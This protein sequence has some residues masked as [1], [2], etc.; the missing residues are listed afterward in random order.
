MAAGVG[1]RISRNIHGPKC[2]L[3]VGGEPL[4]HKTV[5][6]LIRN[7][8]KV[9]VVLGYENTF[10]K[11]ALK[12]L[13]VEYYYNPFYRVTNSIA[14]LWFARDF[15]DED[16]ILANADVF[17]EQDILTELLKEKHPITMLADKSR[18]NKGDYFFNVELDYLVD[19]G[20]ELTREQRTSEYVGIAKITSENNQLSLFKK[21]LEEMIDLGQYDLWWENVL[22]EY[23]KSM[24]VYVKDVSDYFWAEIDYISD[25]KRIKEYIQSGDISIKLND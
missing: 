5:S 11:D 14:S 12:D 1:S 6:M 21:H 24:P 15:M 7:N 25:Y 22:Y 4:I 3:Y 20:K 19:Y 10:I 2:T 17:W 8:I 9:A 16:L 23:L 13:P 18:V